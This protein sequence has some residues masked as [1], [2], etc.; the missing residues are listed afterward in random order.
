MQVTLR[1]HRGLCVCEY[2][3]KKTIVE[4]KQKKL[5]EKKKE[6]KNQ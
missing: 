5:V 3:T 1:L 2:D 6:K 4:N